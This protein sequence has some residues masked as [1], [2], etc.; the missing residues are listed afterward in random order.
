MPFQ[1]IVAYI[2]HKIV[3]RSRPMHIDQRKNIASCIQIPLLVGFL[4]IK[5]EFFKQ[6]DTSH[7]ITMNLHQQGILAN[8]G[9]IERIIIFLIIDILVITSHEIRRETMSHIV[10]HIQI[11]C[12][13][14][15]IDIRDE[16]TV[17]IGREKSPMEFG[18]HKNMIRIG[19][20]ATSRINLNKFL[21][22][23]QLTRAMRLIFKS[24]WHGIYFRIIKSRSD[25]IDQTIH[26]HLDDSLFLELKCM[27]KFS[28]PVIKQI[29][30]PCLLDIGFHAHHAFS[31][32]L[33]ILID[34]FELQ[35]P[36]IQLMEMDSIIENI[37]SWS[38]RFVF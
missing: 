24:S 28:N 32:K 26:T 5:N 36:S 15:F 29:I 30:L 25:I 35:N 1:H 13:L 17:L 38:F 9:L 20:I 3:I 21:D 37:V 8:I 31:P 19:G 27:G 2:N 11:I 7:G 4:I 12:R 33:I 6:S 14:L 23:I 18:E 22:H 10:Q 16:M 34:I